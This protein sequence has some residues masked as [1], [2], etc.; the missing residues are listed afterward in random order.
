MGLGAAA[1]GEDVQEDDDDENAPVWEESSMSMGEG[2]RRVGDRGWGGSRAG[3][4]GPDR[5]DGLVLVSRDDHGRESLEGGVWDRQG[6]VV[7][8]SSDEGSVF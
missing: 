5:G 6:S 4:E 2:E 1:G 3:V 8:Q 7:P